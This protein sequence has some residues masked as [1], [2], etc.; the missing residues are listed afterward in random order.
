VRI[1]Y[2][3]AFYVVVSFLGSTG[4]NAGGNIAH[5]GGALVGWLYISQLRSGNDLGAWIIGFINWIKSFFI[6]TPKIK[7]THR[8]A[9]K[10]SKARTKAPGSDSAKSE[11]EEID[12]ILDKISHS[13]YDSLSKEEKQK[14]FNASKK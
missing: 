6:A 12:A 13:G 5:L 14:L 11:Q 7:V 10:Q 8:S 9:P 4:G 2:I 1:K 3:A